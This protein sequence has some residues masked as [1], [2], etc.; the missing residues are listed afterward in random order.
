MHSWKWYHKKLYLYKSFSVEI[1]WVLGCL[2]NWTM[3]IGA[4]HGGIISTIR[5]MVSKFIKKNSSYTVSI[6]YILSLMESVYYQLMVV[7]I[8]IS[9]ILRCIYNIYNII[10]KINFLW[11]Y[12]MLEKYLSLIFK[13]LVCFLFIT[14]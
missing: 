10:Y 4:G 2:D 3:A 11:Q 13:S 8:S 12:I 5:R 9:N 7:V 14:S 6:K 1:S